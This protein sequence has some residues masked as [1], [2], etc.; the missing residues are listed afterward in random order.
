VLGYAQDHTAFFVVAGVLAFSAL[1]L[2]GALTS[3]L[4]RRA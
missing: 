4:S 2:L 1:V 3:V